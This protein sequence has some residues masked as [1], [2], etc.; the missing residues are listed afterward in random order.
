MLVNE[1]VFP[2]QAMLFT[3]EIEKLVSGV[4]NVATADQLFVVVGNV[5]K[6]FPD[7]PPV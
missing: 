2:W 7:C 6:T 4:S 3:G 5:T 1:Q